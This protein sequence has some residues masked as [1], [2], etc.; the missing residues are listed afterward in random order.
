MA[1][2]FIQTIRKL[3]DI[4]TGEANRLLNISQLKPIKRGE[5]FI[6]EGQIPRKFA[7][8]HEGLFRY[9]YVDDKGS[10]FTKGFFPENSFLSSYSAMIQ[11]KP[12]HFSIEALEDAT[13]S[14][15]KYQDWQS[16]LSTHPCWQSLLLALIEKAFIKKESREREFLLFDAEKRYRIFLE[17]YPGLDQRIKQHLIA[18][19]LGITSVALS[20]I[21]RKMGV[22][23]LG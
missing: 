10:E 14:V 3:A 4:P 18:S 15:I 5:L 12:S 23:N 17:N 9:Y 8:I 22:V 2:Q 11:H 16:I 7:F 21:R 1:E 6:S 20:R 13:I 19:Y